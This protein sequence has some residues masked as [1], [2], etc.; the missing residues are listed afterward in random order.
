MK[1]PSVYP[2]RL[3]RRGLWGSAIACSVREVREAVALSRSAHL[4][5]SVRLGLV[6]SQDAA[7]APPGFPG[8]DCF[9]PKPS[10]VD[11]EPSCAAVRDCC[12]PVKEVSF[13]RRDSHAEG[14]KWC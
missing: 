11:D 6:V 1:S 3:A 14:L 7:L 9:C 2:P 4:G 13:F 5:L 8:E 10:A 12:R